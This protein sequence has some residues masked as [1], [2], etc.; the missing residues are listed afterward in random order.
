MLYYPLAC[1]LHVFVSLLRLAPRLER[2]LILLALEMTRDTKSAIE[3]DAVRTAQSP[4]V[5]AQ[6]ASRATARPAVQRETDWAETRTDRGSPGSCSSASRSLGSECREINTEATQ[7]HD[8]RGDH[9]SRV[10][11]APVIHVVRGMGRWLPFLAGPDAAPLVC[12][13]D[14]QFEGYTQRH[15]WEQ[16]LPLIEN[17]CGGPDALARSLML[18]AGDMASAGNGL[19]GTSSDAVPDL[20]PFTSCLGQHGAIFYVYGNHDD[21]V[22]KQERNGNG[23][24]QLLPDGEVVNSG[25]SS[26]KLSN[27][28]AGDEPPQKHTRWRKQVIKSEE[29]EGLR[30]GGVH[31]IPSAQDVIAGSLWK[32]RPR[33][34]YFQ[35]MHKV[36]SQADVVVLHSN[37]KLPGQ[38]EVEGTDA[39]RI[40]SGFMQGTARLLVHGHMHTREVVTVVSDRKVV[41]NCDCRVVVLLPGNDEDA[42]RS[43]PDTDDKVSRHAERLVGP[44][45]TEPALL[46]DEHACSLTA[47]TPNAAD[48]ADRDGPGAIGGTANAAVV[49]PPALRKGRW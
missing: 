45:P 27:A 43:P 41:V 20:T 37:P 22:H 3:A 2:Q 25:W 33:A 9:A 29:I 46:Q 26:R 10:E 24:Q 35:Q 15:F 4:C 31:G 8:L 12:L 39:P 18:V 19:R 38:E 32:K 48:H 40:F 1:R 42:N 11:H 6:Q 49:G 47:P 30:I 21:E 17:V 23:M 44:L 7:L 34:V 16:A 36:C 14:W 5:R 28:V 13:S